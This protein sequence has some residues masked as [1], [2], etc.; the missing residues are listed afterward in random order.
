[1]KSH[2]LANRLGKVQEALKGNQEELSQINEEI[3]KEIEAND[4]AIKNLQEDNTEL[5]G[6][7]STVNA[8]VKAIKSL[9]K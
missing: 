2:E 6:L 7:R 1:M 5:R 3:S 9:L 4:V 8:T